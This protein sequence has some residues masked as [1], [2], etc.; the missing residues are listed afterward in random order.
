MADSICALAANDWARERLYQAGVIQSVAELL[1]FQ[2]LEV[3]VRCLMV[4]GMLLPSSPAAA[5]QLAD[6]AAAV[7]QLMALLKQN[8]DM[9]CKI[10]ARDILGVLLRNEELRSRVEAAVRQPT[11]V[12]A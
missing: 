1:D 6:N 8:E 2:Q 12:A 4:L 10:I 9:D 11:Q 5:Q 3:S 7:Q